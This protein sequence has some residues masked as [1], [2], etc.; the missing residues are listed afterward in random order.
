MTFVPKPGYGALFRNT[1][2]E[3]ANQ[4]DYRGDGVS[5]DGT[6]LDLA[7]WLKK[8]GNGKTYLSLKLGEPRAKPADDAPKAKAAPRGRDDMDDEIPFAPEWR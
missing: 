8:D 3:A 4:P 6:A 1:K 7:G 2:K 5:Y